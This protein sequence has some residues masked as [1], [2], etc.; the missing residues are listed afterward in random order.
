MQPPET[1]ELLGEWT[2]GGSLQSSG[3]GSGLLG[4]GILGSWVPREWSGIV[5]LAPWTLCSV[6]RGE[7]G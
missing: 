1:I 4:Q 3:A 5:G 2:L 7:V 6:G